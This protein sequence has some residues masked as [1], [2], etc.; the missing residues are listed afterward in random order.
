MKYARVLAD[1]D[2]RFFVV[3]TLVSV[4][5]ALIVTHGFVGVCEVAV[6]AAI[7]VGFVAQLTIRLLEPVSS[8][9]KANNR[10]VAASKGRRV[11]AS[12]KGSAAL[13]SADLRLISYKEP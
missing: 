4:A 7:C 10:L 12:L 13:C 5:I 9:E 2:R 8:V 11:H 3:A 1:I 6:A